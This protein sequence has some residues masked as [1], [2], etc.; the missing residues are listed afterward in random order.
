[1]KQYSVQQLASLAQISVRTLHHYDQIGILKPH[2]RTAAGYR[3]YSIQ[4]L[5]RLQQILFY[6]ELDIPLE[7]IGRILDDP[8]FDPIAAL[9][10][11]RI[12]I[13]EKQ[14]R[15]VQL[16]VTIDKTIRK[17][18]GKQNMKSDEEYYKGFSPE[19]KAAFEQYE[20]EALET[21][22]PVLVKQINDKAK[23]WSKEK[24]DSLKWEGNELSKSLA[25]L[26][27]TPVDHPDVQQ[28]IARHH[29]YLENFYYASA[30]MYKGLAQLYVDD[31][32]FRES[33]D[34]YRPGLADYL[35]EAIDYYCKNTLSK[36]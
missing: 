29:A 24:W 27:G 23:R 16:L 5:L 22:D 10:R 1:M 34:T 33:Y 9:H 28:L 32:R 25:T 35:K 18:H 7:E 36:K 13:Q 12:S 8:D 31:P 6:K 15:Y 4:E 19:E 21:Y 20:M 26:M 14:E 2:T 3:L 17:L 30:E 11:H